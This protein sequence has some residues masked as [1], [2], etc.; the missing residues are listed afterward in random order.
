MHPRLLAARLTVLQY[1]RQ[2]AVLLAA[3][4]TWSLL[5]GA[6]KGQQILVTTAP[7][8]AGQAVPA[9]AVALAWLDGPP[10]DSYLTEPS[11]V[12]GKSLLRTVPGDSPLLRSDLQ[13]AGGEPERIVV[14]LP[15]DAGAGAEYQSGTAV[16]VWAVGE[17]GAWLLSADGVVVG[18]LGG[19][20]GN[21]RIVLS[22]PKGAEAAAM[23]V[24]A[25][26]LAV[27]SRGE[28]GG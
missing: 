22:L 7:I 23:S 28:A 18:V 16:H 26:R 19:N 24:E 27:V 5:N 14:D 10:T 20:L 12:V 1:R 4:V 17:A 2:L 11:Q 8:A 25:V 13:L 6:H 15:L 3:L 9:S 21:P